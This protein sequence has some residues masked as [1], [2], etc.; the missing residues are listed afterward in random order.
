MFSVLASKLGLGK[1]AR[2]ETAFLMVTIVYQLRT[3]VNP[4][5]R[6]HQEIFQVDGLLSESQA[7]IES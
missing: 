7:R 6:T 2:V 5:S 4:E 3:R 1:F